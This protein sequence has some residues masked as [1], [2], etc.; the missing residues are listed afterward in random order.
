MLLPMKLIVLGSG[1]CVPS[2]QRHAPGYL[3]LE[4]SQQLLIDCGSGTLFQLERAGRSYRSIDAVCI[5]HTH[6]DHVADLVPLLQALRV[7]PGFVRSQELLILG[8]PSVRTLLER[9][10]PWLLGAEAFV[11]R[12]IE[13]PGRHQFA[14]LRVNSCAT[15]HTDDSVAYRFE[16]GGRSLVITGDADY[17]SALVEFARG[18]DLLVADCSFPDRLKIRGHMSAS[19]CGR[20]AE[21]AGVGRLLLSHLYPVE[22][23]DAAR[24]H[25]SRAVYRGPVELAE[26]LAQWQV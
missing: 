2:L 25:E 10:Y 7:T 9:A 1:T 16:A 14:T 21:Q 26:D 3:L 8:P 6:P 15:Q 22:A 24:L 23:G 20:L 11:T 18:A 4:G 19:E 5:T 17:D 12:C 13:M